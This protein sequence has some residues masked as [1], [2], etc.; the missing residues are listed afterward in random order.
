MNS[1][2]KNSLPTIFIQGMCFSGKTTVGTL[3]AQR[4]KTKFLDSRYIFFNYWNVYD[5]DYLNDLGQKQFQDAE[6]DS[7]EQD[8]YQQDVG[9]VA[10]SG[11]TLYLTD[12]MNN[13]YTQPFKNIIIWLDAPLDTIIQRKTLEENERPIVYPEGVNSFEELYESR[14]NIYQL[15]SHVTVVIKSSDTKEQ[16][17]DKVISAISQHL[18]TKE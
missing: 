18:N 8:F 17:V 2:N 16:V 11:S 14:R 4:L 9:V 6:R 5:L 12:V 10:L 7:L 15:Y 3:L 13:L 1:S